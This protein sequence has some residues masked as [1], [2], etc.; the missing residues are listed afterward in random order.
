MSGAVKNVEYFYIW[1][2][3]NIN[4]SENSEYSKYLKKN[5]RI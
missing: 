2:D 4:N 5:I 3:A 1:V